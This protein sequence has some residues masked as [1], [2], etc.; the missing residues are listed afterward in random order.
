MV[1]VYIQKLGKPWASESRCISSSSRTMLAAAS[2]LMRKAAAALLACF[3]FTAGGWF[4]S[5]YSACTDIRLNFQMFGC[6]SIQIY[7]KSCVKVHVGYMQ[8]C[9]QGSWKITRNTLID[10]LVTIVFRQKTNQ[11]YEKHNGT[12]LFVYWTHYASEPLGQHMWLCSVGFNLV[13]ILHSLLK[14]FSN[15]YRTRDCSIMTH[16]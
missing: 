15:L 13:R 4:S 2:A 1:T 8:G 11:N 16:F 3:A 9:F 12:P 7:L 6:K 14:R 5:E 10:S